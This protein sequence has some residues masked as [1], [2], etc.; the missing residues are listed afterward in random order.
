M[1]LKCFRRKLLFGRTLGRSTTRLPRCS[2]EGTERRSTSGLQESSSTNSSAGPPLSNLSI[3]L[4]R[5]ITS[6]IGN[7]P[8]QQFSLNILQISKF[9][10]Q[11]CWSKTIQIDPVLKSAS[12]THGWRMNYTIS[13]N[14]SKKALFFL[15]W[16]SR[17]KSNA[18]FQ[19][20]AVERLTFL[21]ARENISLI[22]TVWT[23]SGK[24]IVDI[25]LFYYFATLIDVMDVYDVNI[26]E[27]L[28]KFCSSLTVMDF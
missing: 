28:Q 18:N 24:K 12:R 3:T 5:S 2:K 1:Y 13:N 7:S 14:F 20:Y 25:A 8:F 4:R 27:N 16:K 9:W 22:F 26:E 21:W 15:Q 10:S 11:R 17:K 19:I 23:P 6:K